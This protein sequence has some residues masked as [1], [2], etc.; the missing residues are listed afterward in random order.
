MKNA[1]QIFTMLSSNCRN[2]NFWEDCED[3]LKKKRTRGWGNHG[4]IAALEVW[5]LGGEQPLTRSCCIVVAL[6]FI[7]EHHNYTPRPRAVSSEIGVCFPEPDG[8]MRMIAGV[9]SFCQ[10]GRFRVPGGFR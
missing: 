9:A 3:A 2:R 6:G 5:V 10:A 8:M 7:P 4:S 1:P